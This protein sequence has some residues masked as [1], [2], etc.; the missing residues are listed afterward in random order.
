MTKI[1]FFYNVLEVENTIAQI[2][3]EIIKK[4][5]SAIILVA[6]NL[7]SELNRILWQKPQL[8]FIPHSQPTYPKAHNLAF[9]L[10]EDKVFN[11]AFDSL[12][13][14]NPI[15]ADIKTPQ[16]L[17]R[18]ILIN[19]GGDTLPHFASF[20]LVYEIVPAQDLPTYPAFPNIGSVIRSAR[21][22]FRHYRDSGY[23]IFDKN[24]LDEKIKP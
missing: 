13:T 3:N 24:L 8:A 17:K 18:N 7:G 2:C 22:R 23:E 20:D 16:N 9:L 4:R 15:Y 10:C 5:E 14:Y 12:L 6:D 1:N 21:E 19:L 11:D